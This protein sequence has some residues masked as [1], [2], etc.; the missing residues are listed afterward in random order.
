[1]SDAA[2]LQKPLRH[3][4]VRPPVPIFFPA[5][6]KVPESALH[7][8]LRTALFL[9]LDRKLRG[10]AYVGSDQFVYWD[11]TDPKLCLA[12]DAFVRLGGPAELLRSYQ[13]WKHGA[14]E[15]AVEIISDTDG[16]PRELERRLDRYRRCAVEELVYFDPAA[17]EQ[18]LKLW[19]W[20]ESDLVERDLSAPKAL[21]CDALDAYWVLIS[22]PRLGTMLRLA[23]HPDGSG[24]WPT[25][26]EAEKAERIREREAAE[27]RIAE[28]EAELR[29]RG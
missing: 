20:V 3:A 2:R 25:P 13:T 21:Y 22:D 11:A 18:P 17:R 19:D 28:L 6:E 12:P 10:R 24:L 27:R 14:P 5:E 26:E 16:G 9:I 1:M 4:Y 7:L 23:D 29:R 8:R 15:V